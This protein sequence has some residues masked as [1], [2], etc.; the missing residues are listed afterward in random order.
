MCP[1]FAPAM[2]VSYRYE[3]IKQSAFCQPAI[4]SMAHFYA[5]FNTTFNIIAK[6]HPNLSL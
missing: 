3:I 1:G 5:V 6:N 2:P 4:G